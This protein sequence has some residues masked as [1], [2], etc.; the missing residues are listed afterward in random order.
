MEQE[1]EGDP[2]AEAIE[3]VTRTLGGETNLHG[4]GERTFDMPESISLGALATAVNAEARRRYP[5]LV[6]QMGLGSLLTTVAPRVALRLETQY[7]YSFTEDDT[8]FPSDGES[9]GRVIRRNREDGLREIHS[10]I[11]DQD[12]EHLWLYIPEEEIWIDATTVAEDSTVESD[13]YLHIFLSGRY[14]EVEC[15]HT[16][17]DQTAAAI[18]LDEP[19]SHSHNYLL[20]AAQPSSNDVIRHCQLVAQGSPGCQQV[21]TIVS[22]YGVTSFTLAANAGDFDGLSM[23]NYDRFAK[24]SSD[25]VAEI[26]QLLDRMSANVFHEDGSP[27]LSIR[28]QPIQRP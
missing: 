11:T 8:M 13:N 22:H 23:R 6:K 16:H 10:T 4:E 27:A 26:Q 28:F 7:P 24:D 1:P 15:V 18:A 20:E 9:Y 5:K 25:P 17:V 19:W 14:S 3:E 12:E 21:T 2:V